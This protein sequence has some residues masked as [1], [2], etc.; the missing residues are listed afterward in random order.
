MPAGAQCG[1]VAVELSRKAFGLKG[2]SDVIHPRGVDRREG[3]TAPEVQSA[4]EYRRGLDWIGGG[5]GL[6]RHVSEAVQ[7]DR[8]RVGRQLVSAGLADD[9]YVLGTGEQLTQPRYVGRERVAT[10]V[11][12]LVGP[13]AI[14]EL[15]RRDRMVDVDQQGDQNTPLTDVTDFEALPVE[16]CL[17]VAE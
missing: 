13:H 6:R 5:A 17:D 2:I 12:R 16:S 4:V 3:L 9:L 1:I 14:D 15:I 10:L 11:R 8:Q 7:V